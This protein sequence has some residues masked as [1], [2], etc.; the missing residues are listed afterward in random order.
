MYKTVKPSQA[1]ELIDQGYSYVD[2]R[3]EGEFE[4]GHPEGA[5]NVPLLHNGMVPNT[6]FLDV[7]KANF[8]SD[9]KLVVGCKSGGRSARA[10]EMLTGAGYSDVVNMD[11]GFHGRYDPAGNLVQ[12]GWSQEDLPTSTEIGEGSSY[13][14]L[15]KAKGSDDAE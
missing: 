2:V 9:A 7:M 14:S 11:G 15:S 4:E 6:E 8:S 3:T 1:K 5:V 12:S 13:A 10:A